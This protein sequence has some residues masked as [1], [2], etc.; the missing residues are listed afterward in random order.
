MDA[1]CT[2]DVTAFDAIYS[3]HGAA[4]HAYFRRMTR[5]QA[6]A[7]DLLQVT[8][9]HLVKARGRY[10]RGEPLAPW[11]F[12]IGRNAARDYLRLA[13]H[14]VERS[15][16]EQTLA[17]HS[18]AAE[19]DL[20][21]PGEVKAVREALDALPPQ[22][23]EAV[24]LHQIEGLPFEEV[25]RVLGIRAGAAKVRAHRGYEK[26]RQILSRGRGGAS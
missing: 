4:L 9:V 15:A 21:D 2:G 24:V 6:A 17:A 26:L 25:G 3:R 16:D 18:G 23:R 10:A 14:K 7:D 22:Q 20:A 19:Q 1:F 12:S 5:S 13:R 11:L 8:F